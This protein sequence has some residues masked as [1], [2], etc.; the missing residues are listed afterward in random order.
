MKY[1]RF[2]IHTFVWKQKGYLTAQGSIRVK[3][4][5]RGVYA[6]SVWRPILEIRQ[7]EIRRQTNYIE[8]LTYDKKI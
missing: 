1:Q 3:R 5:N 8:Q 4:K 2:L 7:T 6:L